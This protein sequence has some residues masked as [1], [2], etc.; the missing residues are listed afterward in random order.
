MIT[1]E[2]LINA[3]LEK[4]WDFWTNP[5]HIINWNFASPDWH[6]PYVE[7][8]LRVNG[9]FKTTMASRDG[10]TSFDFE[11]EYTRIEN[12]SLIEYTIIDGRKVAIQ[13]KKQENSVLVTQTFEPES[14]N[15]I[16][17]QQQG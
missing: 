10:K 7:N 15:S 1:V 2:T 9:K 5:K 14:E 8:D 3:S 6:T 12:H 17:L 13:F 16:A 4:V 11:G